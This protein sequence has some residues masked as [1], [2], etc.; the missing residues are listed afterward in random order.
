MTVPLVLL[1]VDG[2]L[3]ALPRRKSDLEAWPE[4]RQ[5]KAV[6]DGTA[7]PITWAPGLM[8]VL[9]DWHESGRLE[10]QWLTTWG[11]D[12]NASLR[13]LLDLPEFGVAGTYDD[14][15]AGEEVEVVG[16]LESHAAAAP[17]APDPLSGRWWKYDVVRRVLSGAG[18]RL[19]IW[20]DDELYDETMPFR[21]WAESQ[22]HLLPVGPAPSRGLEPAHVEL[23]DQA[24]SA[25]AG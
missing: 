2:V 7:W 24:A 5:G 12:A 8:Q 13:H 19:V 25:A 20:V 11:Y 16:A 6:A 17:S 4:W 14:P 23:I 3:N 21:A 22:P 9:R 10:I 1:D 18:D 15:D